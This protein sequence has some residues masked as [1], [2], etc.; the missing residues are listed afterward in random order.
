LGTGSALAYNESGKRWRKIEVTVEDLYGLAPEAP[1]P[2]PPS[3]PVKSGK[4]LPF[5]KG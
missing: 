4:V 1:E 5:K 3:S 2:E